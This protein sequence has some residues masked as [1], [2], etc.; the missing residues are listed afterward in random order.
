MV[1][2][3][4]ADLAAQ[5]AGDAVD[6]AADV[7]QLLLGRQTVDVAAVPQDP[8]GQR[9]EHQQRSCTHTGVKVRVIINY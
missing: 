8:A 9:H 4:A 6:R 1:A 2:P 3:V 5:V 7:S